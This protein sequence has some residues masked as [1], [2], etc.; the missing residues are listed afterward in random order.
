MGRVIEGWTE[1]DDGIWR[2]VIE[3]EE[4]ALD[5]RD[6]GLDDNLPGALDYAERGFKRRILAARKAAATRAAKGRHTRPL[7]GAE[8]QRRY[9]ARLKAGTSISFGPDTPDEE[10]ARILYE[11]LDWEQIRRIVM[12]INRLDDEAERPSLTRRTRRRPARKR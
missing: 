9:I 3:G 7:S 8:R 4:V 2:K 10:I 6:A 5:L 12:A 1:G 11:K